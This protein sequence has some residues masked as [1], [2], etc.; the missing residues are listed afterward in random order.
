MEVIMKKTIFIIMFCVF[1]LNSYNCFAQ[2]A[3]E[4]E[5]K[6]KEI[7]DVAASDMMYSNEEL[8][9]LYYQNVQIIDLLKQIKDLLKQQLEQ[10]A[11]QTQ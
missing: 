2:D 4:A 11:K 8:K 5:R 3:G 1:F 9:A 7:H 10:Q 6:A